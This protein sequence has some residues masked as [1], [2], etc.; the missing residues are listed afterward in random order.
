MMELIKNNIQSIDRVTCLCRKSS[1][2]LIFDLTDFKTQ[3]KF[4]NGLKHFWSAYKKERQVNYKRVGLF[5]LNSF[6][7]DFSPD[8]LNDEDNSE[9]KT[10]TMNNIENSDEAVVSNLNDPSGSSST[11]AENDVH[12]S[13]DPFYDILHIFLA[14]VVL[15]SIPI[16]FYLVRYVF[17]KFLQ[18]T[19]CQKIPDLN[20]VE[21]TLDEYY[22]S[23]CSTSDYK[24]IFFSDYGDEEENA[25]LVEVISGVNGAKTSHGK[26]KRKA[27]HFP[28]FP[29]QGRS[30]DKHR[31]HEKSF[32][33][34]G[35]Y[36]RGNFLL[37]IQQILGIFTIC[38]TFTVATWIMGTDPFAI[39]AY[40]G[41]AWTA[42]WFNSGLTIYIG[43]YIAYLCIL[44]SD[45]YKAGSLIFIPGQMEDVG[46]VYDIKPLCT[47]ILMRRMSKNKEFVE[48]YFLQV[49]NAIVFNVSPSLIGRCK[50]NVCLKKKTAVNKTTTTTDKKANGDNTSNNNLHSSST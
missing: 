32:F 25:D 42:L 23:M 30:Q 35:G 5:L 12:S 21:R 27:H 40:S 8:R 19:R 7:A 34:L 49:P 48:S 36:L 31:F 3:Q 13:Q 29:I 46:C 24:P 1:M 10:T 16:L 22:N 44:A 6:G 20:H 39:V 41:I 33:A 45:K 47:E 11:I 28:Q 15:V 50:K 38:A 9:F 14:F 37:F 43:H 26:H 17:S 18:C 4:Y 2:Y